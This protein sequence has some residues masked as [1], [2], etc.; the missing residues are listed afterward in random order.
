MNELDDRALTIVLDDG[1]VPDDPELSSAV[2]RARR[3]V[4]RIQRRLAL[5]ATEAEITAT[6]SA[7][8]PP[9]WLGAAAAAA[10]AVAG[11]GTLVVLR[12][13]GGATP[14]ATSPSPTTSVTTAPALGFPAM[15]LTLDQRVAQADRI[16][17]GTITA[18]DRGE[19][20]GLPYVLAAVDVSE[21]IKPSNARMVNPVTAFDYNL[22]AGGAITSEG[23]STPWN[24]GDRVLLFLV[25]DASTV[26]ENLQ[27]AHLQVAEGASGR[28]AIVN[29]EAV[30]PFTLDD[31]RAAAR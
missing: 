14:I 11:I 28:Y 26:S 23:S 7:A 10:I 13:D 16:V 12:D 5:I 6:A 18:I 24:I 27:P 31:V 29:G 2:D 8:R 1:P 3:D 9:R 20:G 17:V 21:D 15:T 25:S 4:A 22:G 30:A 19:V